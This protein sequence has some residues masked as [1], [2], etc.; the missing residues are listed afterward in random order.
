MSGYFGRTD[1]PPASG[2]QVPWKSDG[3][4][5]H[6]LL[7][8]LKAGEITTSMTAKEVITNH[9]EF[10]KYNYGSFCTTLNNYRK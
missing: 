10:A 6:Y 2:V 7:K 3:P 4:D 1:P 5:G 9:P 8:L